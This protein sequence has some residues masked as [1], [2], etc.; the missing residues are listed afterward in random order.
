MPRSCYELCSWRVSYS[1]QN[2]EDVY[3]GYAFAQA[4][5]DGKILEDD[6]TLMLS[7]D[8]AQLYR[9]KSSE[10]WI[11]IWVILDHNPE[12]RYKKKHIIPG[13][14]IPGPEK[15]KNIDSFLFPG[16]YHL[17]ALQREGL[18]IW[19]AC[20]K[21]LAVCRPFLAIVAADGPAMAW[22]SGFVGHQGKHHCRFGCPICGRRK[23]GGSTYY[24]CLTRPENY[25]V[26]GSNHETID[27]KK[28][29]ETFKKDQMSG[30][31][32]KKYNVQVK[33]SL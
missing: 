6:V 16:M 24:P 7:I 4:Y 33:T 10:C 11:Y 18:K 25:N 28:L 3:D 8:G 1:N 19:D 17:S 20:K 15:P 5:K 13:A 31:V 21:R 14:I 26:E 27:L 2:I 23:P 9:M 32:N 12:T 22:I 29:M 30:A